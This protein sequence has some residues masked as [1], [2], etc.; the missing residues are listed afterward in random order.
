MAISTYAG[1]QAAVATFIVR[2]DQTAN[3]PTF[4][5]LAETRLNRV[6]RKRQAEMDV[7][8]TGV[9]GSRMIA[10]PAAYSEALTLWITLPGS[11]GR[12]ELNFVDPAVLLTYTDVGQPYAWTI[13]GTNLAFER[14]CDQAY[15]FTL[16]CLEKY[17][18]SDAAPTNAL[19]TDYPDAYLFATLAEAG[20]FLRDDDFTANYEQKL[21]R[22]IGEI[23][24][25]DARSRAPQH[26]VTE[27]GQLQ[28]F[29][30]RTG[31]SIRTDI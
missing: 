16:R 14:P 24:A 21:Q 23:N 4:I 22:T 7:S 20:P 18:L 13:D 3:I 5:Q 12:T 6:L 27:P 10:L 28:R 15:A 17:A 25:K 30:R 1:L 2:A 26:L 8:L 31:Y 11:G 19:L 29:G 9:P